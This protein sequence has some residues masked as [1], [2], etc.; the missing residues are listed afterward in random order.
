MLIKITYPDGTVQTEVAFGSVDDC[1]KALFS[2]K[3]DNVKV[4]SAEPVVE[5]VPEVVTEPA[6]AEPKARAA[7]K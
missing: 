6:K 4:E 3:P 2:Q 5:S 7:K 1:V